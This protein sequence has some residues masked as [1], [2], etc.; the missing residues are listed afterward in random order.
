MPA[1][2]CL[3]VGM[4]AKGFPHKLRLTPWQQQRACRRKWRQ[5]GFQL[6]LHESMHRAIVGWSDTLV[7]MLSPALEICT[8]HHRCI[9]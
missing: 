6:D 9:N 8:T 4:E 1:A 7:P 2:V 3:Q 5:Q